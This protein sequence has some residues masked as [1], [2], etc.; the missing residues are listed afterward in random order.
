MMVEINES[1]E[2]MLTG[3]HPNSLGRTVEVVEDLLAYPKRLA[4][5]Y[6]CYFSDDEVVRLRTSNALKRVVREEPA[7]LVPYID[8]LI[9]EIGR[10][11]QASAQWTLAQIFQVLGDEMTPAQKAAATDL[12][13][14]NL[15]SYNDWIVINH[16][17]QT[18][19]MWA[20]SDE[21]LRHWL[22]PHLRRLR[23]EKRKSIAKRATRLLKAL[24]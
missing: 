2:A 12:L 7:W 24:A 13:K 20:V 22:L 3:G 18:L 11:D 9:G 15:E 19:A 16:T 14:R 5:L 1:Y 17:I 6:G 23:N 8:R 10:L 21:P 4:E